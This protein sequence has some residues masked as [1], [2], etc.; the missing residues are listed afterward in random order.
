MKD[1]HID[2]WYGDDVSMADGIDVSFNDLDCKYRGNIYKNGRM[3][4]DYSCTDS[5]MLENAFKGLFT[6]ESWEMKVRFQVLYMGHK[7]V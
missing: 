1:I 4:G 5:V 2:M 7:R 6:W 3:I